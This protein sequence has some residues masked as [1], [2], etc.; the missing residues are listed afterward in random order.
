MK[1][2]TNDLLQSIHKN[3]QYNLN[4]NEPVSLKEAYECAEGYVSKFRSVITRDILNVADRAEARE[5]LLDAFFEV[6]Y[7]HRVMAEYI[8]IIEVVDDIETEELTKEII[9]EQTRE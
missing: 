7:L 3:A 1:Y 9:S 4:N 6:T 8:H 2:S 5:E